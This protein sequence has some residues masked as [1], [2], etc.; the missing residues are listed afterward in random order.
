MIIELGVVAGKIWKYLEKNKKVFL[1]QL[2]PAI[3]SDRD[4]I[5]MG[6]GWMVREGYVVLEKEDRQYMISLREA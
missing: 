5:L 6:L 1:S 3:N 4:E 2:V